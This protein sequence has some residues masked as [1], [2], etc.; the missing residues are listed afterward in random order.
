MEDDAV[1]KHRHVPVVLEFIGIPNDSGGQGNDGAPNQYFG[2]NVHDQ[3][4]GSD[5]RSISTRS[6]EP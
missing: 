2:E 6:T 1:R 4:G 5:K 3:K